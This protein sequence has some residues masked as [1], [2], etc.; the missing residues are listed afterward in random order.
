MAGFYMEWN[1]GLKWVKYSKTWNFHILYDPH[2]FFQN[3]K[4]HKLNL[5]EIL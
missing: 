2:T 5:E 1:T 4:M 3:L